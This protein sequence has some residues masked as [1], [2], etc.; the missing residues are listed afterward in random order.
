MDEKE[1][2]EIIALIEKFNRQYEKELEKA[3]YNLCLLDLCGAN[4]NTHTKILVQLLKYK[5]GENYPFLESLLKRWFRNTNLE[6]DCRKLEITFNKDLIDG[7]ICDNK[8]AIIIENKIHYAQDQRKQIERYVEKVKE[9]GI[10][11]TNIHVVYLT[12]YGDKKVSGNSCSPKLREDLGK[13]FVESNYFYDILPWLK[14]DVLPNCKLKDDNLVSA[15]KQYIDHLDGMCGQRSSNG[16]EEKMKEWLKQ[17]LHF[18]QT[19]EK[20]HQLDEM[21]NKVDALRTSLE[22]I[23]REPYDSFRKIT[24]DFWK[25]YFKISEDPIIID[26][27]YGGDPYMII[28][29]RKWND[30]A[31]MIHLEWKM[32]EADFFGERNFPFWLHIEPKAMPVD[33]ILDELDKDDEFKRL[34][35]ETGMEFVDRKRYV[36]NISLNREFAFMSNESRKDFLYVIYEKYAPLL[37]YVYKKCEKVYE[38]E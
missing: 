37:T 8:R 31:R 3:P 12:R 22:M 24:T 15:L 38:K 10:D 29:L 36:T 4:E 6:F 16:M 23:K 11:F 34:I 21:I 18:A 19:P 13:R 27:L 17:K 35:A 20:Y 2:S 33:K 14:E 7:L 28:G 5:A 25:D 1:V 26:H 30:S 32:V 9:Y